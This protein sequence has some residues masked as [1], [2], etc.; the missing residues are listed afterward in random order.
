MSLQSVRAFLSEHAP[1]LEII[2]QPTSTATVAEAAS[3]HGVEPAQ[4]AKTLSLRLNGEV[5]LMVMGGDARIHN[6]KFK[7]HF[8]A[9]AKLLSAE[10]VIQLTGHPVGGVCPFGLSSPLRVY[11]DQTLRKFDVV[12][13]AAGDTNAT[14]RIAPD[15]IAQLAH[16]DWIDIAQDPSR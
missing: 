8:N 13:L 5:I 16:A 2:Q 3:A 10:E 15:R 9:K 4:I 12:I 11:A 7:A 6:Q 14:V 1:D